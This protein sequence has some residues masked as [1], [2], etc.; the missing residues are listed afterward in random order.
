MESLVSSLIKAQ[1]DAHLARFCAFYNIV[2]DE[3]GAASGHA[4][5]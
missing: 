3:E 4:T 2:D 5:L 1:Q